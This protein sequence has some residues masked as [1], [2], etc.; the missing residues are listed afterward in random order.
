MRRNANS[1]GRACDA[2]PTNDDRAVD[3]RATRPNSKAPHQQV[4]EPA[5]NL[6]ELLVSQISGLVEATANVMQPDDS[7]KREAIYYRLLGDM[8]TEKAKL[9]EAFINKGAAR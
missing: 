9:Y 5:V 6:I 7:F 3:V 8:L 4:P 2:A 1:K